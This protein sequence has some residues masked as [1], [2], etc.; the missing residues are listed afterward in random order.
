MTNV[1]LERFPEVQNILKIAACLGSV[2]DIAL[3]RAVCISIP[4][5]RS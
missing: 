5:V 4:L 1:P 2:I 3:P